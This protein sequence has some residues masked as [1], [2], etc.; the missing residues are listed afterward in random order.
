MQLSELTFF[1]N[2]LQFWWFLSP[3]LAAL[4]KA[5]FLVCIIRRSISGSNVI[6]TETHIA[7]AGE[8]PG[9]PKM[10]WGWLLNR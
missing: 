8:D 5:G 7:T 6:T 1:R 9:L 3:K 2:N 10:A 4:Y